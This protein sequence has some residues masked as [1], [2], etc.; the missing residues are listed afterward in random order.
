VIGFEE[1][2]G[3]EGAGDRAAVSA[4]GHRSAGQRAGTTGCAQPP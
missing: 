3:G 2:R 1:Q 4:A